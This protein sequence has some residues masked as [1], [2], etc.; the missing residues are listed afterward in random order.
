MYVLPVLALHPLLG[1]SNDAAVDD[2]LH[3]T[4]DLCFLFSRHDNNK[5]YETIEKAE[6][7]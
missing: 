5:I 1:G 6:Q 3:D 4:F 2:T 7:A